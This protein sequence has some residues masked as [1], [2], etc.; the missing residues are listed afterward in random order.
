M[1]SKLI[2][3]EDGTF[4][5]VELAPEEA[6]AIAGGTIKKVNSTFDKIRPV[7]LQQF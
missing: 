1:A 6:Q 5:E 2:Q 7:L 4:V 3:L